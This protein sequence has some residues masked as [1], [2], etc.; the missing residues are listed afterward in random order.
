MLQFTILFLVILFKSVDIGKQ[1]L[2]TLFSVL[3]E[4]KQLKN[5]VA[6]KNAETY[7]D[8]TIF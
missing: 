1:S 7:L 4:I 8:N 3:P 5:K 6:S 2:N